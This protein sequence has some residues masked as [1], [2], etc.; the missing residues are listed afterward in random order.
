[1]IVWP[2]VNSSVRPSIVIEGTS[3]SGRRRGGRH[4]R[5]ELP[6]E[7]LDDRAQRPDRGVGERADR[8]PLDVAEQPLDERHVL[9][10]A[11]PRRDSAEDLLEPVAALAA[12]RALP[13]RLVREE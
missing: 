4:L 13:A 8:A 1:M 2:G 12:R 11:V 3:G 9:G 7:L 5:E 6:A 10:L